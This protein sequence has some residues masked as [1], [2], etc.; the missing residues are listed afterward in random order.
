MNQF[1]IS[2]V[3][4]GLVFA[5]VDGIWLSFVAN[6]FY[7]SQIGSLLLDKPNLPAAVAFYAVFLVG[8]VVFVIT[9]SLEAGSIKMAAVLGALFGLVTYA[10]YDLTNLATLKNYSLTM[11]VVDIIWGIVLSASVSVLTVI[12]IQKFIA[13]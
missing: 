10:T 8:L 4:S 12:L 1:F 2:Y 6:S 11:A 7:R 5:V 13:S 9:P 3:V